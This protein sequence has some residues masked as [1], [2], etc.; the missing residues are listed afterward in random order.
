MGEGAE[1]AEGRFVGRVEVRRDGGREA[2]E[3]EEVV[4]LDDG[5]DR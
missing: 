4:E 2:G 1:K 5:P 3:N